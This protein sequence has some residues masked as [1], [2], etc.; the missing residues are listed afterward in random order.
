MITAYTTAAWTGLASTMAEA[1]AT[2]AG[3]LFVAVSINLRQI[4]AYPNLPGRAAQTLIT[5]ATAL[6]AAVFVLVPGQSRIALGVEL[7]VAGVTIGAGLLVI[8]VRAGQSDQETAMTRMLSRVLPSVA[9]CGCLTVAGA[10]LLANG[11]GG[12]Y[13]LVPTFVIVIVSGLGNAWILLVE[14]MR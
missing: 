14:I 11:G 2:L 8:D 6:L 5:F 3:L 7:A 12:L 9:A 1:A 4:L 13:W 10:S